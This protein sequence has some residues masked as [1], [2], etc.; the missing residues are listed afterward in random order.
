MSVSESHNPNPKASIIILT[1]NQEGTIGRAIESVLRQKCSYPYEIVVADDCSPDRTREVAEEY[2]RRYPETV[3]LMP[4]LPNRG[5]V[6]NYFDAFEA[7]R[8]EYISDCAGDD[9]WL[10][11]NR[12]Q[13]QIEILDE[14]PNVSAVFTDVEEYKVG[15]EGKVEKR[16][17]S[18]IPARSRYMRPL[19]AGRDILVGVLN[20]VDAL[21]YTL[22]AALYRKSSVMTLYA[23]DKGNLRSPASGVEDLAMIAALAS[24]GD[25]IY[26][27]IVGYRYYIDGESVSNNLSHRKGYNFYLRATRECY[28][29]SRLYGVDKELLK[30]H[31][32]SKITFLATQIHH[33]GDLSLLPELDEC[34]RMWGARYTFR[35]R[36]HILLAR[37]NRMCNR[38]K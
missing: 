7:C 37:L 13:K 23:A 26:L 12:L 36:V 5:L 17:H 11:E 9:E 15:D 35:A 8:G 18:T 32:N 19:V 31:Y 24:Q 34:R 4:K 38:S 1:Y 33:M 14:N 30:D 21:P 20:N 29:L 16:L 22:S 2:A 6:G 25:A 3:R 28:R 10:D 27:P